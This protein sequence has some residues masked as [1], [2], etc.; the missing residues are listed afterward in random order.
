MP[1]RFFKFLGF[2]R[3]YASEQYSSA[4]YSTGDTAGSSAITQLFEIVM[5]RTCQLRELGISFVSVVASFPKKASYETTSTALLL[6]IAIRVE[7]SE[8][9]ASLPAEP[10]HAGVVFSETIGEVTE[11]IQIPTTVT[12]CRISFIA[13]KLSRFGDLIAGAHK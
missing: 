2:I 13:R 3:G 11:E 10:G 7:L 6:V 9:G 5:K 1:G 8:A 12:R 4:E